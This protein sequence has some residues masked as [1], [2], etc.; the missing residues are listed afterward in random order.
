MNEELANRVT[1][2]ID[3]DPDSHDR[4]TLQK[5]LSDGDEQELRRRFDSPLTFGTAG[6]RGPVMAGPAGMNWLTVR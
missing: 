2:W 4:S 1:A 5:L 3:L 6:L